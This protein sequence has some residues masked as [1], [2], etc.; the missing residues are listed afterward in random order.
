M[1]MPF[2]TVHTLYKGRKLQV[3]VCV[4]ARARV[5]V[6]VARRLWANHKW[7]K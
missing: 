3:C 7:G 2:A 4:F 1:V 6:C 5:C